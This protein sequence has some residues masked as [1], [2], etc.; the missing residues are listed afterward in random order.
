MALP[1]HVVNLLFTTYL[2][3]MSQQ[4]EALAAQDCCV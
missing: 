1:S 2:F 4:N 3:Y